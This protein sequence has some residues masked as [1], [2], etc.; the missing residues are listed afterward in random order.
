VR[1]IEFQRNEIGFNASEAKVIFFEVGSG[2]G[3]VNRLLQL[4]KRWDNRNCPYGV[5]CFYKKKKA[6]EVLRLQESVFSISFGLVNEPLPDPVIKIAGIPIITLFGLR[7]LVFS[8][9]L[10]RK[11]RNAAVYINNTP[12]THIPLILVAWVMKRRI[13]C[14]LRDTIKFSLLEKYVSR[15]ISHFVVLSKAALRFYA[16]QGIDSNKLSVIY[17]SIN[18]EENLRKPFIRDQGSY[19]TTIIVGS[20]VERKGQD[21][22][23]RALKKVINVR[24]N[25]RLVLLG[26][27]S[28]RQIYENLVESLG[29]ADAV[30]FLGHLDNVSAVLKKA[31]IGM[32]T[33][34]REGM[35]NSVMEYM[36]NRLPVIVSDLPGIDELV[37]ENVSGF[38]VRNEDEL[39]S[40]WIQL[41]DSHDIRCLMGQEGYN[42]ITQGEF[43][44]E[45]ELTG[46]TSI[47]NDTYNSI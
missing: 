14:H 9:V 46:I 44:P 41:I 16:N 33:S 22:A 10:L 13:I 37:A 15:H 25:A 43:Y 6:A 42:R 31:D 1:K 45:S 18:I 11:H 47:I 30:D 17:D 4:L 27:G 24:P 23:I 40:K 36:A 29:L 39:V 5:V 28:A 34:H 3:S 7:Y 19:I 21:V 38:I 8:I 20:L 26:D 32:L 12:Y 35:P 2:G